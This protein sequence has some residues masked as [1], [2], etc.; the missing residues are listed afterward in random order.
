MPP[1]F[2]LDDRTHSCEPSEGDNMGSAV[3]LIGRVFACVCTY[4]VQYT[5]H[6]SKQTSVRPRGEPS[7]SVEDSIPTAVRQFYALLPTER[8]FVQNCDADLRT[9]KY[10]LSLR[11]PARLAHP[12]YIALSRGGCV[13]SCMLYPNVFVCSSISFIASQSVSRIIS[14]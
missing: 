5:L 4:T 11:P 7:A 2:H 12:Y 9:I 13:H 8:I 1:V 3:R 10:K 14:P 6:V